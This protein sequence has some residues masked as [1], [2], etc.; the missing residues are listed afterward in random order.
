MKETR[1]FRGGGRL[2]DGEVVLRRKNSQSVNE[3]CVNA[4]M[5]CCL[6]R[7]VSLC[8]LLSMCVY[9][10][11]CVYVGGCVIRMKYEI[12]H[13]EQHHMHTCN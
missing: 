5:W 4:W 7:A 13:D 12:S 2:I 6:G 9:V 1:D 11:V 10:C 3:A 8:C